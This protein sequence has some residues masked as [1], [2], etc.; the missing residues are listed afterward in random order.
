VDA[1]YSSPMAPLVVPNIVNVTPRRCSHVV[2]AFG[3][4]RR[5]RSRPQLRLPLSTSGAFERVAD[6]HRDGF[7]S[8]PSVADRPER[9]DEAG[10]SAAGRFASAYSKRGRYTGCR[11]SSREAGAPPLAKMA[12][13]NVMSVA[14]RIRFVD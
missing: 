12:P 5:R 1:A 13:V 7:G 6:D 10:T 3:M 11:V 9:Q 2:P 4:L 8:S 14:G